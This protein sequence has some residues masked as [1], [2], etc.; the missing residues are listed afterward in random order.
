[1]RILLLTHTFNSLSQRLFL[2]LTE[3]SH[4]V[5]IEFDIN[6]AV[7]AEATALFRP[8]LIIAPY[9]KRTIPET[10]WRPLSL[11]DHTPWCQG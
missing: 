2:E 1:M 5:S 11:P 6:D 9:L 10:I 3:R 4:E 7:T 8:D